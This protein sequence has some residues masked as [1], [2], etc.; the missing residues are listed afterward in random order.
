MRRIAI[1]GMAMMFLLAACGGGDSDDSSSGSGDSAPDVSGSADSDATVAAA[2]P[3]MTEWI[4]D[5]NAICIGLKEDFQAL[6]RADSVEAAAASLLAANELQLEAN[7]AIRALGMPTSRTDSVEALIEAFDAR[8]TTIAEAV[9]LAEAG[10]GEALSQF[11]FDAAAVDDDISAVA[12]DLGVLDCV[13]LS[14]EL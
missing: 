8:A 5:V 4:D 11:F 3:P 1:A 6:G 9:A 14:D 13:G 12:G 10:D 2:V 7:A